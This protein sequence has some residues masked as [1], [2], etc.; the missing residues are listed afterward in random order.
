MLNMVCNAVQKTMSQQWLD[1]EKLAP[2]LEPH[3][4]RA[5]VDRVLR[6]DAKN[7]ITAKEFTASHSYFFLREPENIKPLNTEPWKI[8]RIQDAFLKDLK[9]LATTN[10]KWEHDALAEVAARAINNISTTPED[11]TKQIKKKEIWQVLRAVLTGG[12]KGP[13]LIETM[14]IL[15]PDVVMERIATF[16]S[17]R[18]I[19]LG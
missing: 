10:D 8:E 16:N 3:Q 14:E 1:K 15:G 2:G 12:Q 5:Y 7:Y 13:S 11:S 9:P 19:P 18:N 6:A 17:S 4:N